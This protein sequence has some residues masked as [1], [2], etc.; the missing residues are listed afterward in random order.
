MKAVH[1]QLDGTNFEVRGNESLLDACLRSGVTIP[2]SCRGGVCHTC[3]LRCVEGEIPSASQ[4]G[5]PRDLRN[6]HYLLACQCRPDG[7]LELARPLGAD[8][9]T[10]CV[11]HEAAPAGRYLLLRFETDR[12][13]PCKPGQ[14]LAIKT[15]SD[16]HPVAEITR[17]WPENFLIE[18]LLPVAGGQAPP[19]WLLDGPGRHRFEVAGPLDDESRL[20]NPVAAESSSPQ[21][22]PAL[23]HELG[24]G[25]RVRAVL[26]DFYAQVYQDQQLAPFFHGV[27]LA[28]SIDKQYSFLRQ[29]MTGERVYFG[30]RPRN[31]HHWMV[32]SEEMFDYRQSLMQRQLEAH[33]LT[34][35]QIARWSRLELHYRSDIVKNAA[36]PRRVGGIDLPLEGFGVQVIDSGTMCDHC[37]S[38]VEAGTE[39]TY[40]LR[41]GLVSCGACT[42]TSA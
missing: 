10:P 11:L 38:A 29:L 15:G 39:V 1:V 23:W 32:I 36:R 42:G 28:R 8:R 25:L 26:E 12:A 40:H 14:R 6:K 17:C 27:T 37:G 2:F 24:D 30:D 7:P 34:D 21:P 3:L 4:R 31:A 33:G 22:D 5:L 35:A 18:A 9:T 16:P 19:P 13:L 20:E 41:L